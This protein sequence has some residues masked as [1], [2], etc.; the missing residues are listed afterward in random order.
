MTGTKKHAKSANSSSNERMLMHPSRHWRNK[1]KL[2]KSRKPRRSDGER[3]QRKRRPRR[4]ADS[5]PSE[6]KLKLPRR[7]NVSFGSSSRVWATMMIPVTMT[8]APKR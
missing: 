6:L 1:S 7:K 8:M 2:A 5:Q 3:L 4:K